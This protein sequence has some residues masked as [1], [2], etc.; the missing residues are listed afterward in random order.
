MPLLLSIVAAAAISTVP[1]CSWNHPGRDPYKGDIAAAVDAYRDIPPATRERLK[2]RLRE[3]SFD[4]DVVI[5]RDSIS[6]RD[7]YD[8]EIRGMHFGATRVCTRVSR[9]GWTPDHRESGRV[10]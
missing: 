8:P 1:E 2:T 10:V 3:Q 6:G 9:R 4:D 5:T 7:A